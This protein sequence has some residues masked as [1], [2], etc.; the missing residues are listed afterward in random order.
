MGAVVNDETKK[1]LREVAAR[2]PN[3][4]TAPEV[5]RA[6][7]TIPT[8]DKDE[9]LK[10]TSSQQTLNQW[11]KANRRYGMAQMLT[12]LVDGDGKTTT[13]MLGEVVLLL[14]LDK[15]DPTAEDAP[16]IFSKLGLGLF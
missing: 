16:G 1:N 9:W 15:L 14:V 2:F 11:I 12:S 8:S 7:E 5:Y 6:G 4:G 13:D 3:P 10:Q